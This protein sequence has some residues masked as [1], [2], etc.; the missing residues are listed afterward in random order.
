LGD[1]TRSLHSS[2]FF[3]ALLAFHFRFTS[4]LAC[5]QEFLMFRHEREEPKENELF[6]YLFYINVQC[7][8]IL[9]VSFSHHCVQHKV[10]SWNEMRK[11]SITS[12]VFLIITLR[13][14]PSCGVSRSDVSERKSMSSYQVE[15]T[16]SFIIFSGDFL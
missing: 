1:K 2:C 3:L 6:I 5:F 4:F 10:E 14:F 8:F 13:F 15:F 9:Y 16:E 12:F 7:F 11:V